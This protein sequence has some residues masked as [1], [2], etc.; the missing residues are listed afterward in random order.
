ML[1]RQ[2]DAIEI[3]L[4]GRWQYGTAGR[5]LQERGV[6]YMGED[7]LLACWVGQF[8]AQGQR[9][10]HLTTLGQFLRQSFQPRHRCQVQPR[11]RF[12]DRERIAGLA[13]TA[14]LPGAAEIHL[15]E[16]FEMGRCRFVFVQLLGQFHGLLKSAF[17]AR[18]FDPRP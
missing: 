7:A 17:T 10:T 11:G 3:G 13:L 15:L 16:Q 9:L 18:S 1:K 6:G 2:N 4:Q 14:Q 12:E 5:F 8:F